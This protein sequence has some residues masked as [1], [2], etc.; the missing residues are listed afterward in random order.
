MRSLT[1]RS[2]RY[3]DG[4]RLDFSYVRGR[5]AVRIHTM[6]SRSVDHYVIIAHARSGSVGGSPRRNV[7]RWRPAVTR[8]VSPGDIQ[9]PSYVWTCPHCGASRSK[10]YPDEDEY[11][12]AL[13]A[14]RLHIFNADG[15]GH[16]PRRSY[17][18][19]FD[20]DSLDAHVSSADE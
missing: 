2:E 18:E 9:E 4:V 5:R 13:Q 19:D 17:P 14:L 6:L 12:Q 1:E 15:E 16:G 20:A 3:G 10:S 11:K 7:S 8:G